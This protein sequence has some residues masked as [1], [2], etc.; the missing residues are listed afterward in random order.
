MLKWFGDSI[1][2][3]MSDFALSLS[4]PC[5]FVAGIWVATMLGATPTGIAAGWSVMTSVNG[6]Q[7][8]CVR[9]QP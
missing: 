9:H 2:S 3:L 7:V 5:S 1:V 6:G 8:S 4:L